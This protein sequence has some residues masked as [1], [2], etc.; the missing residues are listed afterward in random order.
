MSS[1][2]PAETVRTISE[3]ETLHRLHPHFRDIFVESREDAGLFRWYLTEHDVKNAKIFAIDDRVEVPG[4]LVSTV[5]PEINKRGR[6]VALAAQADSWRLPEPTVTCIIDADF[7]LLDGSIGDAEGALLAT[8][9]A[10][11]EVYAL[12]DRPLSKFLMTAAR[13]SV[14]PG[15]AI[16]SLKHAWAI[17][18]ALRYVIHREHDG[19]RLSDNFA[20]AC[21][22]GACRVIA[23]PA[24]LV[25]LISPS[26]SREVA[27]EILERHAELMA[28]IPTD[29]LQGIRGH[30][31]AP[32]LIRYL[33]LRNEM[34]NVGHV[35]RLLRASLEKVD[36]DQQPLFVRLIARVSDR[37]S[38]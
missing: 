21:V 17:V 32:M 5:H 8:D 4:E 12:E 10:A 31:A 33:G 35:E 30:D 36:L 27:A 28:L 14:E 1:A 16:Q 38:S 22:D 15:V 9:Y 18:F 25:R 3:L 34:A 11:V 23:N 7:D 19:L 37:G 20:T 13:A 24:A 2:R 6:L 26:P 29:S